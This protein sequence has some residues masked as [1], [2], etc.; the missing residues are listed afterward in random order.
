MAERIEGDYEMLGQIE[1][2]FVQLQETF[3]GTIQNMHG[4]MSALE[5]E[6][7]GQ[8]Y[9]AFANE[10]NQL[11][12]PV[13]NRISEALLE[14]SAVT[15]EVAIIMKEAEEEAAERKRTKNQKRS[16]RL[17]DKGVLCSCPGDRRRKRVGLRV[18][19][20]HAGPFHNLSLSL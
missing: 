6:W 4:R 16:K 14:A 2:K 15:K 12:L 11:I 10:M 5:G 7:I 13:C 20:R 1:A 8:G 17:N 18:C 3:M 19:T 9:D